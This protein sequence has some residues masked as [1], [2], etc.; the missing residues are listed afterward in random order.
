MSTFTIFLLR[1]LPINEVSEYFPRF[2]FND[3][4]RQDCDKVL[5][6]ENISEEVRADLMKVKSLDLVGYLSSSLRRSGFQDFELDEIVSE[7]LVRLLVQPGSLFK[8][9]DRKGI[10]SARLKVAIRN[11]VITHAKQNQKRVRRYQALPDAV[12]SRQCNDE[13][14]LMERFRDELRRRF[15]EAGVNVFDARLADEDIKTLIGSEGISSSYRLKV[16]VQ[17][18]KAVARD[19]G[20]ECLQRAVAGMVAKES[21]TIA[22]RFR[23]REFKPT[24]A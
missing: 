5:E 2:V 10:M 6:S 22:K 13:P 12:A 9:W 7:I 23:R 15:G 21:E 20:D 11:G 17:G 14:E 18:I 24:T 3:L 19:F 4:L 1:R 8:K 16:L